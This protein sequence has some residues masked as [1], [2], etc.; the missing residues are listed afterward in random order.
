MAE[1]I[2]FYEHIASNKRKTYFLIAIVIGFIIFLG[3]VIGLLFLTPVIGVILAV[4][5]GILFTLFA[6]YTGDNLVLTSVGAREATKQEF[7][8]LW[9]TVEGLSIAAG[10]PMPKIYVVDDPNP[11][12]F[13]TGRDPKHAAVTVTTSLMEIMNRQELEGVI[14]H[15]L[16]HIRNYD[17]RYMMLTTVLIGLVVLLADFM[18]RAMFFSGGNRDREGSL[19]LVLIGVALV[20]AILSPIFAQ[21]I[22]FAVSRKREYLADASGAMI[23]R[24]PPGLAG[25]LKKLKDHKVNPKTKLNNK[26]VEHLY[27]SNPFKNAKSWLSTH[28]DIN[29]RIKKLEAM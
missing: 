26:A 17:I 8:H 11:N 28:P 25:A 19:N 15:E 14:A 3:Y 29:D 24:Y 13:A 7:P 20:F 6:Y 27:I 5:V 16:S 22:V 2:S 23:T 12:A 9:H 18:V 21:L 10:I 1:R 4:I